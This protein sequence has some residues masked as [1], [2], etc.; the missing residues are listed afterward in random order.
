MLRILPVEQALVERARWLVR[1]RWI[2]LTGAAVTIYICIAALHLPLPPVPLAITVLWITAYNV[3]F[4][5]Y[6]RRDGPATSDFQSPYRSIRRSFHAQIALD[7]TALTALLHYSG[8]LENPFLLYFIFHSILTSMLLSRRACFVHA[9][10]A[11]LLVSAMGIAEFYGRIGHVDLFGGAIMEKP[12]LLYGELFAFA[13]TILIASFL[14][15]GFTSILRK[16]EQ[17]MAQL[18]A[19]LRQANEALTDND[20]IRS[21]YVLRVSHDLQSPLSAAYSMLDL[22]ST[23]MSETMSEKARDFL[24]RSLRRL[25]GLMRF[26]RGIHEIS[27]IRAARSLAVEPFGLRSVVQAAAEEMLSKVHE[28]KIDLT[29]DIPP[30]I[31]FVL[32]DP[33]HLRAA[34]AQILANSAT[35]ASKV[36]RITIG[37]RVVDG[38]VEIEIT[39]NGVGIP[40]EEMPRIFDEFYRGN[41]ARELEPHGWGLG[42]TLVKLIVD[43]HNGTIRVTS[44]PGQGSSFTLSLPAHRDGA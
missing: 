33:D 42:L 9:S 21:E 26:T 31:P 37:A 14:T 16:R 5:I 28:R 29:I 36:V 1:L 10:L 23:T 39:D 19:S 18:E 30:T 22:V 8:G 15:T 38:R 2:A 41:L 32:G 20:R 34:L 44:E 4:A 24:S 43:R 11:I 13:T 27:R 3:F 40:A 12:L 17:E 35:Y 6:H 7:W 25:E